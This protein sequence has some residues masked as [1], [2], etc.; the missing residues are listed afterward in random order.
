[1]SASRFVTRGE[2]SEKS[3]ERVPTN[4][5]AMLILEAI[6]QQNESLSASDV[7]RLIG[8]PKQT[9]H[10]LCMTLVEEGFLNRD[11]PPGNFRPGRRSR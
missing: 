11:D 3:E 5:R 1:M 8:I 2:M 6:G 10:R 7:G 9:A 4:L